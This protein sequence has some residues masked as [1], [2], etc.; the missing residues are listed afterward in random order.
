MNRVV[1]RTD[2]DGNT[3]HICYQPD[4]SVYYTETPYQYFLDGHQTCTTSS[5]APGY[6]DSFNHDAD[7]NVTKEYRNHGGTFEAT[8]AQPTAAP[9][10]PPSGVPTEKY[11]D[12]EDRLVEVIQPKDGNYDVFTNPWITRYLY[13]L[14][15]SG[16]SANLSFQGKSGSFDAYGNLYKTQELLPSATSDDLTWGAAPTSPGST[17]APLTPI[18]NNQIADVSATAYDSANRPI[19]KYRIVNVNHNEQVSTEQL[20]YDADAAHTGLLSSDCELAVSECKTFNYNALEQVS[21]YGFTPSQN[22]PV[23]DVTYDADGRLEQ[24]AQEGS[25]GD[26]DIYRYDLDGRLTKVS[27]TTGRNISYGYYYD[28]KRKSLAG[29]LGAN[30]FLYSYAPDGTLQQLNYNFQD[31]NNTP[32]YG[33][34]IYALTPAGRVSKRDDY[35]QNFGPMESQR[36]Y[37]HGL[38]AEEDFYCQ[39]TCDGQSLPGSHKSLQYSAE[40]ELLMQLVTAPWSFQA[41]GANPSLDQYAEVSYYNPRGELVAHFDHLGETD[42]RYANGVQ[43][44]EFPKPTTGP[45]GTFLG[46]QGEWD[47]RMGAT[48]GVEYTWQ[49]TQLGF[50]YVSGQTTG[51]GYDADGR[52]TS[53]GYRGLCGTNNPNGCSGTPVQQSENRS[54]DVENHMISAGG[55]YSGGLFN[56]SSVTEGYVWGANGHPKQIGST[57]GGGPSGADNLYWDG[58]ALLYTVTNGGN[59]T[60]NDIKIGSNAD[61]LQN[62]SSN[63]EGVTFYDRGSDGSVAFCHNTTGGSGGWGDG[64]VSITKTRFFTGGPGNPCGP[65]AT[66]PGWGMTYPLNVAW[67]GSFAGFLG[68]GGVGTSATIGQL[69]SD[70]ITDGVST[71][72]GTRAFDPTAGQWTTPDAYPGTVSDPM[73][74]KSYVWNNNNPVAYGDSSGLDALINIVTNGADELGHIQIIIYDPV[75][76]T[77]TLL[78]VQSGT[79]GIFGAPVRVIEKHIAD[80]RSLPTNDNNKYYYVHTTAEQN[81]EIRS[82]YDGEQA[83]QSTG[84]HY[85]IITN[86]CATAAQEGLNAAGLRDR[87]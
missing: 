71:V 32:Y 3:S 42:Y 5:P 4:G 59:G 7:G 29:T 18:V 86:D 34:M 25:N 69:R 65:A 49:Q 2:P 10:L 26:T 33:R 40:G 28:G 79:G 43:V 41:N 70:G 1:T 39:A 60:I 72:Q 61:F 73:T 56:S 37:T 13:D 23:R 17:P 51:V 12:G 77:G 64:D 38:L 24:A 45:P 35:S 36:S 53:S 31:N 75:T 87:T 83:S 80:V 68:S 14:T 57:P 62:D 9:S 50:Q 74:K 66:L 48:L 20:T 54:Y 21:Q 30:A 46:A 16:S 22:T 76:M 47:A 84:G 58:D 85:N 52:N 78:S 8:F 82:I 11:Y 19:D 6:A 81:N 44:A 27:K 67:N 55:S 15:Q 63:Y